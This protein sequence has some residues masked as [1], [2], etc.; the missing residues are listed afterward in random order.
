MQRSKNKDNNEMAVNVLIDTAFAIFDKIQ[1]NLRHTQPMT[2]FRRNSIK[3]L[4][5]SSLFF[6]HWKRARTWF[7][8]RNETREHLLMEHQKKATNSEGV[9]MLR[10]YKTS[11]NLDL[12]IRVNHSTIWNKKKTNW[13]VLFFH[14]FSVLSALC[15]FFYCTA[16]SFQ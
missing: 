8:F 1:R 7:Q 3:F 6:L 16:F 13:M 11:F 4:I 10:D 14:F 9:Y 12:Y 15:R 5:V 2:S